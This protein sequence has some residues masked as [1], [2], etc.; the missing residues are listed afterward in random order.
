M[1]ADKKFSWPQNRTPTKIPIFAR[2]LFHRRL[3]IAGRCFW[4]IFAR[5]LVTISVAYRMRVKHL[6]PK[7]CNFL[8]IEI[9]AP[10]VCIEYLLEWLLHFCTFETFTYM[11]DTD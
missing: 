10:C 8:K 6:S 4:H 2:A 11:A 5:L 3:S 1:F 9:L 7:R